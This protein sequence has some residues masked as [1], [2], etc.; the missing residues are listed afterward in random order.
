[1][2]DRRSQGTLFTKYV[3]VCHHVVPRRPFFLSG[4]FVVDVVHVRL[5]F[6][7]LFRFDRQTELLKNRR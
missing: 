4:G 2:D 3:N 7:D 1:M 6:G 5:H